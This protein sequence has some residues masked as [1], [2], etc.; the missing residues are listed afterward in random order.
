MDLTDHFRVLL[1]Y[2]NL[3]MILQYSDECANEL[4]F[5]VDQLRGGRSENCRRFDGT[6]VA[7]IKRQ[8]F[9]EL[10]IRCNRCAEVSIHK[11]FKLNFVAILIKQ[12]VREISIPLKI[13]SRSCSLSAG[14]MQALCENPVWQRK[15]LYLL[16]HFFDSITACQFNNWAVVC[17]A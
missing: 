9:M 13:L 8:R 7:N 12:F 6:E 5:L 14:F 15:G 3:C 11:R 10:Q 16:S 17:L 1:T 4:C 2:N